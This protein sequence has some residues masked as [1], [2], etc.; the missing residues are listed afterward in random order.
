MQSCHVQQ[1]PRDRPDGVEGNEEK[2]STRDT[3]NGGVRWAL[4][5]KGLHLGCSQ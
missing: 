3:A 4:M 1:R 5:E 2:A